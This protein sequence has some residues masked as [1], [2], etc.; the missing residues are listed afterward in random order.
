MV[1]MTSFPG[2]RCFLKKW[3]NL[4]QEKKAGNTVEILSNGIKV[5][6]DMFRK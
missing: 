1:K 2:G 6:W 4:E 3:D 5:G